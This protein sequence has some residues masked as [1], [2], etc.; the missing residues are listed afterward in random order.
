MACTSADAG[1][2]VKKLI[3]AMNAPRSRLAIG[4][5]LTSTFAVPDKTSNR[6]FCFSPE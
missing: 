6:L 4:L 2:P 3:S 5:P 1:S